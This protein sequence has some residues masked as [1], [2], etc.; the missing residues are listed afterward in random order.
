MITKNILESNMNQGVMEQ[1]KL[2]DTLK[3]IMGYKENSEI[4]KSIKE[5]VKKFLNIKFGK[6]KPVQNS[7][8][9]YFHF[10][11]PDGTPAR[12]SYYTD[13][14]GVIFSSKLFQE[15]MEFF[16]IDEDFMEDIIKEW[17]DENFNLQVKF[18]DYTF[19]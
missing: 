8:G 15:S 5:K 19:E 1:L 14:R 18:V 2:I 4:E 13:N 11:N 10:F 16:D 7:G 17:F 12:L 6:I 9:D 3:R